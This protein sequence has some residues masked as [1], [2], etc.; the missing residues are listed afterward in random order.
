MQHPITKATM[1]VT[2]ATAFDYLS[3]GEVYRATP[4]LHR[5][6]KRKGQLSYVRFDRD[7]ESCG[8][9]LQP[10]Q[11]RMLQAGHA[12]ATITPYREA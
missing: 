4:C 7:D 1:R 5:S 2:L 9:F 11:W 12:G 3:A 8:T 10:Y 6:G